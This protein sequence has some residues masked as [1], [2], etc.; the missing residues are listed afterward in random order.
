MEGRKGPLVVL[1][2]PGGRGGG[3]NTTRYRQQVLKS[4]LLPF[5]DEMTQEHGCLN[6]QQDNA[7]CHTSKMMKKWFE[8]HSIPL[9][10]HPPNSP[11]LSPIEPVWNKLKNMISKLE[12]KPST[13]DELIAAV[14]T[15]WD[16][17][18]IADV[19]KH[20]SSMP[21]RVTAVLETRGGHTRF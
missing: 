1:E 17:L 19:D 12:K 9:L 15:A 18:N 13:S 21:K 16:Q 7:S 6:F 5:Y 2:Y 8:D 20:I 10:Y 14:H 11:D 3:M 4:A